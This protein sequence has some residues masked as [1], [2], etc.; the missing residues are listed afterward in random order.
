MMNFKFALFLLISFLPN[1]LVAKQVSPETAKQVAKTQIQSNNQLRSAQELNLIFTKTADNKTVNAPAK[2]SGNTSSQVNSASANVLYYVFS[3]GEKG[4]VIVAGDDIAKPVLGYSDTGTYDPNNLPPNFVYYMD[5]CLAKEIEQAIAQGITQ[6]EKTKEQWDNYLTGNTA[7]FRTTAAVAPLLGPD[8]NPNSIAWNQTL[9][10]NYNCPTSG[11][12][13]T[14]TGCVAT[15]M[16]QVLMYHQY[17]AKG[18]GTIATYSTSTLKISIPS[19]NLSNETFEWSSMLPQ[20]PNTYSGS[21]AEIAVAALMYDCGIS[22]KMDYNTSS[23]G[24]GASLRTSGSALLNNFS[25]SQSLTYKQRTYYSDDEWNSIVKE[26][27]ENGQPVLYGGQDTGGRGGHAFVCDGDD[28][29]GHFHFN[30]GWSGIA[31]GYYAL[32]ALNP[33]TQPYKFNNG[34]E[35]VINIIPSVGGTVNYEMILGPASSSGTP[36]PMNFSSTKR[37]VDKGEQFNVTAN[38]YLNM[39]YTPI[40]GT[41]GIALYNNLNDE[42]DQYIQPVI[43]QSS[44]Y[45]LSSGSGYMQ[46]FNNRS[47]SVPPGN[48]FI[49]PIVITASDVIPVH[50]SV[51]L[52]LTVRGVTLDKTT[53]EMEVGDKVQLTPSIFIEPPAPNAI[54]SS[55]NT[56]IATV[57][58]NG[59]ITAKAGGTATIKATLS[60]SYEAICT[61]TVNGPP[62]TAPLTWLGNTSDWNVSTNWSAGRTPTPSDTVIIAAD[63]PNFPDLQNDVAVAAI[64]FEPGA[65]IGHQSR[66]TGKAFVQYDLNNRDKWLMLSM[67]LGEAYP[68]D[69]TFGG[70]PQT[71]VCAFSSEENGTIANGSWS[72]FQNSQNPFKRGDGFVVKLNRDD[73]DGY[74]TNPDK[75][76]KL[77]NGIRELPFFQHHAEGSPDSVFYSKVHQAHDYS[78]VDGKGV[79]TF[80]NIMDNGDG[81]VRNENDSYS[82]PRSESAYQLVGTEDVSKTLNFGTGHFALTGNPYMAVLD[83]DRLYRNNSDV[84]NGNYYI[85]TDAGYESYSSSLGD[86]F[87]VI[88]TDLMN[89]YIAP[90]QGFLV[91]KSGAI[92]SGKLVFNETMTTIKQDIQLYSSTNDETI[93][94]DAQNPVAGVRAIIAKR[95]GGQ[96]EFGNMDARKIINSIS[97]V[98]EIYTLKP[99]NDG[100]IAAGVNVIHSNDLLIP[101]GLATSYAG[102]ITLSF[103][104]MD[105]YYTRISFIDTETSTEIN[106]TGLSSYEYRANYTPSQTDGVTVPCENRFFIRISN[107]FTGLPETFAEKVNV[108]ESNGQIQVISA[109]SNPIKEV[110][111]YNLQGVLIYKESSINAISH[112]INRHLPAGAY[113]VKVVSE[114][115]TDNVKLLMR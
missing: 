105:S 70:Y 1:W 7:T 112:T 74:P 72:A 63:A 51:D 62:A 2:V 3:A 59:L 82:V 19:K 54:W 14:V 101:V 106:L 79:S 27:I 23:V 80:Y 4:F 20:Y 36:I 104:G 49:K 13:K 60:T 46:S 76:L 42:A 103:S 64:R 24:S 78:I 98:P 92:S 44:Q 21:A 114:K 115:N 56:D 17:P 71:R 34:Q 8:G 66:L 96:E 26:Q 93:M 43:A 67:P 68:D 102:N 73:E 94:I 81:Y 30:W 84:I 33:N 95:D 31:N 37:Y 53:L 41:M 100:L 52:P 22:V 91:E 9:P 107:T 87:G 109:T 32:N 57:D 38:T 113:I 55:S 47:V 50:T 65:Q 10:Y 75:G 83:L 58:R 16:A 89:N 90:L 88:G 111:V 97:D 6:D 25:Y 86:S 77:L 28:D 39:G 35:I 12:S 108:Y 69:F 5:D 110:A 15:A 40:T 48:Y 85:W 61:V 18:N 29:S 45:T 99:Y 11:G